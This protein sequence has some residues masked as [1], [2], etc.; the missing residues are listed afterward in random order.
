MDSSPAFQTSLQ[1]REGKRRQIKEFSL[2]HIGERFS[3]PWLHGEWG[4]SCRS[5]V[6]DINAGRQSTVTSHKGYF[7]DVQ[8]GAGISFYRAE[9]RP[10]QRHR[11][12]G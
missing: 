2:A 6:A 7:D 3:S 1:F 12:D 10:S 11:D 4:S 9:P 8:A 5:G